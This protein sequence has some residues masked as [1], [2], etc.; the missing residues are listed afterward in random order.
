MSF[1]RC[2]QPQRHCKTSA[3]E[4]KAV[5]SLWWR[6]C[7]PSLRS[8]VL[9]STSSGGTLPGSVRTFEVDADGHGDEWVMTKIGPRQS[10]RS[11]LLRLWLAP[12]G[13]RLGLRASL[14]SA[15]TGER[16]G[17]ASLE[18]LFDFLQSQADLSFAAS[19]SR[20]QEQWE[21]EE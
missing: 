17:F 11:F 16:V 3:H 2:W 1:G 15:Q 8:T 20:T 10:Y 4:I 9:A 7:F 19:G 14:E 12:S 5:P 21:E 6:T 18:A 13:G